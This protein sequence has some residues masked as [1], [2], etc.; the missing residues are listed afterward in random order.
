MKYTLL[1][2]IVL[3][4][5]L[6]FSYT[7]SAQQGAL[8][9]SAY[10]MM[11][12]P[13]T[14]K[15]EAI[16]NVLAKSQTLRMFLLEFQS[17]LVSNGFS[18]SDFTSMHQNFLAD[19]VMKEAVSDSKA[20]FLDY[21][22]P[23]IYIEVELKVSN[24]PPDM[25]KATVNLKSWLTATDHLLAPI[26]CSG[27]CFVIQDSFALC[28]QALKMNW[29]DFK[30]SLGRSLGQIAQFGQ[31]VNMA[32]TIADN[33]GFDLNSLAKLENGEEVTVAEAIEDWLDK[34]PMGGG[35]RPRGKSPQEIQFEDIRL[36][37]LDERTQRFYTCNNLCREFRKSIGKI[38]LNNWPETR[39]ITVE[40]NIV[41]SK[42]WITLR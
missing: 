26:V 35:Y 22:D 30:G 3:A 13:Y 4:F 9:P 41:G 15:G 2:P 34:R 6:Q 23:D 31:P 12:I 20:L 14:Q 10:K 7:L 5:F 21:A 11:V 29:D 27:N 24:C 36:P 42:I 1:P 18:V 19:R 28:K 25:W 39:K 32:L 40:E 38:H 37:L 8:S 17:M 16:S 33:A